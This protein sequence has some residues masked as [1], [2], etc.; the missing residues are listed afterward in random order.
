MN[1]SQCGTCRQFFEYTA[2]FA[3]EKK[4]QQCDRCHNFCSA[5]RAKMDMHKR[6]CRTGR[7]HFCPD[8]NK[9]FSRRNNM[10]RHREKSSPCVNCGEC[11]TPSGTASK[12][13]DRNCSRRLQNTQNPP[14][15]G[16]AQ[17]TE[18]E[19]YCR[20]AAEALDASKTMISDLSNTP[21]PS[22][23]IENTRAMQ[24]FPEIKKYLSDAIVGRVIS[25]EEALQQDPADRPTDCIILCN[26][27]GASNLFTNRAPTTPVVIRQY[28]QTGL[29]I[30]VFLAKL[31]TRGGLDIHDFG[32]DEKKGYVPS[33]IESAEAIKTFQE[34][35]EGHEHPYNLLNLSSMKDNM[36]AI[37]LTKKETGKG[38]EIQG[39]LDESVS[40]H[41]L[42]TKGAAH[43]PH[44]DRHG[45]Y[46]TA[47][48]EE[49]L[50]LW[51]VWPNMTLEQLQS[52]HSD[53]PQE[54]GKLPFPGVAVFLRPGDMLFQPPNT[55]H[56]PITL[57]T[58]LMSGTMHWHTSHL[59]DILL[60]SK[61]AVERPAVTNEA[62]SD[63]L[64]PKMERL[65]HMWDGGFDL[66]TWPPDSHRQ[67]CGDLLD[68]SVTPL[69]SA[70]FV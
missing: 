19:K 30:D 24:D 54:Q 44:I 47:L 35:R 31:K 1:T 10:E 39:D 69:C 56:M 57:E 29:T 61:E 25:A 7:G 2:R 62:M 20:K 14:A 5:D 49:G 13:H 65:L 52:Y 18:I 55:L 22:H 6:H 60:Y 70:V 51:V 68:V 23:G 32:V 64:V 67:E 63:Q 15:Q 4:C 38:A 11:V 43:L 16:Q 21:A 48:N 42:A 28:Q 33:R 53:N 36:E 50:K 46:T 59:R 26:T 66:C 9:Q 34:R 41:L 27:T 8:C 45:V 37:Q 40:F 12:H 3:H 58:C 17:P